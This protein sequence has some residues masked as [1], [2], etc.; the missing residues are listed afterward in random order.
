M[1]KSNSSLKILKS[2]FKF[3]ESKSQDDKSRCIA[4]K[5]ETKSKKRE[6]EAKAQGILGNDYQ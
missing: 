3:R 1:K 6:D 5:I 2:S 4:V